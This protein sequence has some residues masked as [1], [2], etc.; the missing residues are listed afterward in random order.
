MKLFQKILGA[1]VLLIGG[2]LVIGGGGCVVTMI[3]SIGRNGQFFDRWSF[4]LLGLAIA[5]GGISLC[6]HAFHLL[7]RKPKPD[8]SLDP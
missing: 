4:L 3:G 1:F 8:D 5:A 7:R 2:A 6:I